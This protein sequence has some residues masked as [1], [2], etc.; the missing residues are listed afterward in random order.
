MKKILSV[1]GSVLI[2]SFVFAGVE[3]LLY[4]LKIIESG[5]FYPAFLLFLLCIVLCIEI[6]NRLHLFRKSFSSV[7]TLTAIFIGLGILKVIF[8][9]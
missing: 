5:L 7:I 4:G 8:S 2:I 6:L 1:M 3:Y 9:L